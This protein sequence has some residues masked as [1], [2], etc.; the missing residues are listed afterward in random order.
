[1]ESI[2]LCRSNLEQQVW[3]SPLKTLLLTADVDNCCTSAKSC[4]SMGNFAKAI[5]DAISKSCSYQTLNSAKRPYSSSLPLRDLLIIKTPRQCK[6]PIE[7]FC[8]YR[9]RFLQHQQE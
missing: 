9:V 6:E 4:T 2:L 3:T 5:F 1:M 7:P 8:G